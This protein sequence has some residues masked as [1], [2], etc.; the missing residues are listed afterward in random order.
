MVCGLLLAV[1]ALIAGDVGYALFS[2]ALFAAVAVAIAAGGRS[3]TIR[4]LRG[5]GADERF[6]A[7]DLNAT[8]F[9]GSVVIVVVVV[10]LVVQIA[11]GHDGNPYTW[12]AAVGGAA[13]IGA[14]VRGARR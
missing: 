3:E 2:I 4:G 5:D 7:I 6:R 14:H 8:A 9:A 1:A 12:L 13:Y 10:T 11:R